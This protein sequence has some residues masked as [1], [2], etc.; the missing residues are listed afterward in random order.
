M[1]AGE[2]FLNKTV[3]LREIDDQLSF[4]DRELDFGLSRQPPRE[5]RVNTD[6]AADAFRLKSCPAGDR[7]QSDRTVIRVLRFEAD[8]RFEVDITGRRDCLD[9]ERRL[10]TS[11]RHRRRS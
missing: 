6:T 5:V 3:S 8:Q 10:P 9:R 7:E 11:H 1:N 2:K 4:L